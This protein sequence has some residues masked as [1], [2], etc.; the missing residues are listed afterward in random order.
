MPE[1]IYIMHLVACANYQILLSFQHSHSRLIGMC[2]YV[3]FLHECMSYL[4]SDVIDSDKDFGEIDSPTNS[5]A[6][7][8]VEEN[9]PYSVGEGD[10][11]GIGNTRLS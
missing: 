11:F 1:P 3:P 6:F 4:I 10:N 7:D 9:N 5:L 8:D 2:R